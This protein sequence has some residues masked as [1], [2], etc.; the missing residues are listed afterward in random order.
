MWLESQ[1]T[2]IYRVTGQAWNQ[3]LLAL[4]GTDAGPNPVLC[5]P[6]THWTAR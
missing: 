5:E 4:D 6:V 3:P 1:A 2:A